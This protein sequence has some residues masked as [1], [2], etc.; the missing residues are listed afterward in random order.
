MSLQS[1]LQTGVDFHLMPIASLALDCQ[2]VIRKIDV[3][4]LQG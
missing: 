2:H 3:L 4:R 1:G